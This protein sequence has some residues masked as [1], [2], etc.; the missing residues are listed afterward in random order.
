MTHLWWLKLSTMI[1]V[2]WWRDGDRE[3]EKDRDRELALDGRGGVALRAVDAVTSRGGVV[4]RQSSKGAN[5][6]REEGRKQ[7]GARI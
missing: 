6:F 2:K 4:C 1:I 5:V 3:R 7:P